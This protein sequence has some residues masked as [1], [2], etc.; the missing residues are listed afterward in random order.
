M[1]E[2]SGVFYNPDGYVELVLV[3]QVSSGQLRVLVE[4]AKALIDLH[5]PVGAL[6]DG[7]RGNTLPNVESLTILR[8]LQ[9]PKL[10]RLVILLQPDNPAAIQGPTV[11]MSL[12]TAVVG[13][14]PMYLEDEVKARQLAASS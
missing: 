13:F 9:I 10:R 6:I 12:L 3:G 14:R 8:S 7:R 5:G 11:V 4:A 2:K 1:R